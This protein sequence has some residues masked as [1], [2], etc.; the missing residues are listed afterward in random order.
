MRRTTAAPGFGAGSRRWRLAAAGLRRQRLDARLGCRVG[1]RTA[2]LQGGRPRH[3]CVVRARGLLAG[4]GFRKRS[5]GRYA[6]EIRDPVRKAR[7]WLGTFDTPEQ[8]AWAYDAAARR[9]R[10]P[11]DT[12]NYPAAPEP[13]AL[14]EAPA[15][16]ASAVVYESS[17]SS[18]SSSCPLLPPQESLAAVTVAV[19]APSAPSLDLSLALPALVAAANT[20]QL[21]MDPTAAVTPALLQLLPP[22]SEERGCSGLSSSSVGC[23]LALLRYLPLDGAASAQESSWELSMLQPCIWHPRPWAPRAISLA[24]FGETERPP[25][26]GTI[27]TTSSF[28]ISNPV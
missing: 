6:T 2:G 20:Y 7:L 28:A 5:W 12:T 24:S 22:K 21:F 1:G 14:A 10:R 25:G 18:S 15:A 11:G 16:S 17:L 8:V 27:A 19:A 26:F 3:S 13:M 4:H 23:F 9:L